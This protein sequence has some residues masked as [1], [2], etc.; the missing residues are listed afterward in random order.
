MPKKKSEVA[1]PA[2]D[3]QESTPKLTVRATKA[4]HYG[5]KYR[6]PGDRFDIS[7]EEHFSENWMER[8]DGEE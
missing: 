4:G 5:N 1:A 3:G 7:G 8:V 6:E 2:G